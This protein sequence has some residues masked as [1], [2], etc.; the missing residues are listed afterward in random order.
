MACLEQEMQRLLSLN[1]AQ[2]QRYLSIL[3]DYVV[4]ISIILIC[5]KRCKQINFCNCSSYYG[6]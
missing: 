5:I 3:L 6:M 2:F 4:M 1:A